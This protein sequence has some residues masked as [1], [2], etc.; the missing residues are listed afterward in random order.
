[1][2]SKRG[3]LAT[4]ELARAYMAVFSTEDGKKV[5]NDLLEFSGYFKTAPF[6]GPLDRLPY[7][8][9]MR[10]VSGRILHY[11]SPTPEQWHRLQQL[12]ANEARITSMSGDYLSFDQVDALEIN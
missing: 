7:L 10:N 3:A 9:G 11:L 8:E 12:A 4:E 6:D 5:L 2:K 1:M